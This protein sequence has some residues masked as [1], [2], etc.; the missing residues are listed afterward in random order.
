MASRGHEIAET[1]CF[2]TKLVKYSPVN[3]DVNQQRS[4]VKEQSTGW[5]DQLRE[6]GPTTPSKVWATL[7]LK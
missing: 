7:Y 1:Q 2:V 3:D 5:G 4:L 6:S